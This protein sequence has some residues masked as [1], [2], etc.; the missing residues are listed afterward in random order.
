MSQWSKTEYSGVD[1]GDGPTKNAWY[2]GEGKLK[3]PNGVEYVG[4]FHKGEFHGTGALVYP[5]G[6]K[7]Q[8]TWERGF[9][10]E[11]RYVFN[12]GLLYEDKHWQYVSKKDRRFYTE[13]KEGL[14]PAG[15]TLLTNEK[16]PPKIPLGTYDTGN[17]YFNPDTRQVH[18]YDGKVLS[19]PG[20]MEAE[21]ILD[22]C[23]RGF[24]V[25]D[26]AKDAQPALVSEP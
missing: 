8:A 22:H 25:S 17:G 19:T 16:D 1:A 9:A 11:G 15:Q 20:E 18:S 5:N 2:E 13:V 12:D 7:Y 24:D 14:Q 23:R 4:Q 6:G 10:I 3:F 21:W 26:E